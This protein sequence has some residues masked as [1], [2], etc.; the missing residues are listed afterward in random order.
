MNVYGLTVMSSE[1]DIISEDM[2][3]KKDYRSTYTRLF[4]SKEEVKEYAVK[5]LKEEWDCY[6]F[7]DDT[8]E[9]G[10]NI[11]YFE[12]E[13]LK[14]ENICIQMPSSHVIFEFFIE[15]IG[16][17]IINRDDYVATKLWSREDIETKLR[18]KGYEGSFEQVNAVIN[19]GCLKALGDCTDNDWEIIHIAIY[20]A[21]ED[22]P[23]LFRKAV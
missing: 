16:V 13:L 3:G 19:T 23:E 21:K 8:D 2:N 17:N 9:N 20:N 7:R 18:E 1:V 22:N 6:D 12:S 10:Y 14:G 15:D 4:F 11:V 5:R